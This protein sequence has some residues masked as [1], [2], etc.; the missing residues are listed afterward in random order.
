M[1]HVLETK[2]VHSSVF[3]GFFLSLCGCQQTNLAFFHVLLLTE[4]KL[5]CGGTLQQQQEE[6]QE[7]L[8]EVSRRLILREEQLFTQDS[9]SEEEEDQLQRDFEALR[10]QVWMAVQ[11]T[12]TSCSSSSN[13]LDVLRSAVASIQQ[14]EAQDRHWIG[15]LKG[16]VPEWRPQKCL[17]A[18][19]T[20]LQNMV[21]SRLMKATEEDLGGGD[22]LSSALKKEVSQQDDSKGREKSSYS[23]LS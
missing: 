21:E 5:A 20:L 11:S 18:H 17:S 7:Q 1:N 23:S 22:G 13:Q 10:L 16:R 8:E 15:C 19:N 12:F 14:Q 4:G 2:L 9:P 6:T 3:L